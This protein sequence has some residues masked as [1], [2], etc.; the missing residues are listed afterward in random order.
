MYFRIAGVNKGS[1]MADI[2]TEKYKAHQNY[3]NGL[4]CNKLSIE[5]QI[6]FYWHFV[7]E[8]VDIDISIDK[9]M[10]P[11]MAGVSSDAVIYKRGKSEKS[12]YFSETTDHFK[13]RVNKIPGIEVSEVDKDA[14]YKSVSQMLNKYQR[15]NT[16][17]IATVE[18]NEEREL[19]QG[20][21][22]FFRM[23]DY[24]D[25][26]FEEQWL[27]ANYLPKKLRCSSLVQSYNIF[28]SKKFYATF[29]N[30]LLE[31]AEMILAYDVFSKDSVSNP[32]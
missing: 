2:F 15:L 30:G 23:L 27:R 32:Q 20:C 28:D 21:M 29:Q 6:H 10:Q 12:V 18:E 16:K 7:K 26:N 5:K 4:L 22:L 13:I 25:M 19:R 3:H 14:D 17:H 1:L 9:S 24:L 8:N 31:R 11:S